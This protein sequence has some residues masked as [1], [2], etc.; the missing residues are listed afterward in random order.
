MYHSIKNIDRTLNEFKVL[1]FEPKSIQ[2]FSIS[3]FALYTVAALYHMID[4]I[5]WITFSCGDVCWG[6]FCMFQLR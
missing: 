4:K 2:Y 5:R 3:L 1:P 6:F